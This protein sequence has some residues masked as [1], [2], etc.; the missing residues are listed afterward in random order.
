M[1]NLKPKRINIV[2]GQRECLG[3]KVWKDIKEFPKRSNLGIGPRCFECASARAK[4]LY[5]KKKLSTKE[6]DKYI[7]EI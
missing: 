1:I 4:E 6:A 2:N 5:Y 3:C 7:N